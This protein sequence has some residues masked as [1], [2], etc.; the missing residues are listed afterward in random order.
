MKRRLI[1]VLLLFMLAL[2]AAAQDWALD[3]LGGTEYNCFIVDHI[4]GDYGD[5]AYLLR[6]DETVTVKDMLLQLASGCKTTQDADTNLAYLELIRS[7]PFIYQDENAYQCDTVDDIVA[8]YGS[9]DFQRTENSSLSVFDYHQKKAPYCLPRYVI[10]SQR[11]PLL[12]CLDGSCEAD[13]YLERGAAL[14]VVDRVLQEDEQ[15]YEVTREFKH[16][17]D[18]EA[19]DATAFVPAEDV[20]SG[21]AGFIELEGDYAIL[22]EDHMPL[23]RIH[24]LQGAKDRMLLVS[25]KSGPAYE[26]MQVDIYKPFSESPLYV[27]REL[28]KTFKDSGLPYI[29]L[30]FD[31]LDH[32][33]QLGI[34]TVHLTLDSIT[35]QF[36]MDLKE[37]AVYYFLIHCK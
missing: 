16:Y 12:A 24:T 15:W 4:I 23:C 5:A 8:T 35:Y 20:V 30:V 2:P 25:L 31:W 9:F 36:G 6:D 13:E 34:Y 7:W 21:P 28:E 11:L 22:H 33:S 37:V 18:V 10:A 3:A 19:A 32:G 1:P 26:D 14:P 29:N 27:M 17:L